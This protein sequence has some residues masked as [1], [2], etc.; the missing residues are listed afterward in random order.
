[1]N[2][3]NHAQNGLKKSKSNRAKSYVCAKTRIFQIK[4]KSKFFENRSWMRVIFFRKK[5]KI[6]NHLSTLKIATFLTIQKQ[7]LIS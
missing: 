4:R 6:T 3:L 2:K 7:K 1:M 5:S